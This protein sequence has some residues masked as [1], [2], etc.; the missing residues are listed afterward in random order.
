MTTK[1][2]IETDGS[3]TVETPEGRWNYAQ[4]QIPAALRDPQLSAALPVDVREEIAAN[5]IA[6]AEAGL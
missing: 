2:T 1:T 6:V 5:E 4:H 3:L